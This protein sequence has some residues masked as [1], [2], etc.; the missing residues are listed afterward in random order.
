MYETTHIIYVISVIG[1]LGDKAMAIQLR[2]R[3]LRLSLPR[4][5]PRISVEIQLIKL[6]PTKMCVEGCEGA[7]LL[8][9]IA[10]DMLFM[11]K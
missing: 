11:T 3:K 10:R 6:E 4:A 5:S 2:S 8:R 9:L 7:F 1:S